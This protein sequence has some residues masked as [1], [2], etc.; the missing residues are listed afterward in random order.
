VKTILILEIHHDKELPNLCD[1]V[2]GRAYTIGG[3]DDVQ[4]RVGDSFQVRGE[5]SAKLDAMARVGE[6]L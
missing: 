6:V 4:V 2:A 5:S 1:Q 3:V